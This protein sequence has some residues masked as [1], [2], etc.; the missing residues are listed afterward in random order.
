MELITNRVSYRH[1]WMV[2]LVSAV[3]YIENNITEFLIVDSLVWGLI[4]NE[5]SLDIE[6]IKGEKN[7]VA[8][9]LS[10]F[11]LNVNQETANKSTYKK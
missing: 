10:R 1:I 6:Y 5:Y 2:F 11:P 9:A 4:I 7:I 8:D 3:N